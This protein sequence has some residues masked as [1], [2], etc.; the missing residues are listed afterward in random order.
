MVRLEM[1]LKAWKKE[2]QA[3][4]TSWPSMLKNMEDAR[5]EFEKPFKYERNCRRS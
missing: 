4:R 1:Y 2:L 5:A 3:V